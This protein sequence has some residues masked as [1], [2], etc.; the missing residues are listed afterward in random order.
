MKKVQLIEIGIIAIILVLS[1]K[2]IGSLMEL[3]ISLFFQLSNRMPGQDNS[4]ILVLIFPF[5]LYLSVIYLLIKYKNPLIRLLSGKEKDEN[6][7]PINLSGRQLLHT[8]IVVLCFVTLINELPVVISILI[9]SLNT[10]STYNEAGG[11]QLIYDPI[12]SASFLSPIIKALLAILILLFSK[13][14]SNLLSSKVDK[15]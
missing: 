11:D 2:F 9:E 5:V 4:I 8:T 3:I 15:P 14:I 12:L 7:L 1:Y 10:E 13:K 6:S